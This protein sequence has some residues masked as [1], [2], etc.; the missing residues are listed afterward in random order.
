MPR[1]VQAAQE[2]RG[3]MVTYEG[4]IVLTPYLLEF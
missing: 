3:M 4:K 1:V 2:T